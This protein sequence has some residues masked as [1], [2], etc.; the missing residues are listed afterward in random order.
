[1]TPDADRLD[2][3]FFARPTE[4]VAEALVG[5]RLF[6]E[7]ADGLVAGRIIE[8]EAYGGPTDP[9][10]HA[11]MYPRSREAVM[12]SAPGTVYVYRSYGIHA[13]MNV[14]A[15]E[16]GAV[17]AVLL[18]AVEPTMGLDLMRHRRRGC[19]DR[20]LSRGPGRLAQAFAIGLADDGSDV[21]ARDDLW[22]DATRSNVVVARSQRVGITR[23]VEREW[24]FTEA[25]SPFVSGRRVVA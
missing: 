2:R 16:E 25:G 11:A 7:T 9:A 13:C 1:M 23:A 4:V 18:R 20:D 6:R 12:A 15:K 3:A 22:I 19:S 21:V 5:C 14:V 10:S 8:T 17:G 24:R